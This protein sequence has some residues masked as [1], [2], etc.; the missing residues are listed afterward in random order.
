M[1]DPYRNRRMKAVA[2]REKRMGAV[3]FSLPVD[4]DVLQTRTPVAAA[5]SLMQSIMAGLLKESTPFFDEIRARWRELFP[6]LAARPGKWAA[7][8]SGGGKVFIHVSSAS[9]L[10]ALRPKLP[11]IRKKLAALPSA[12]ARFSV[13]LEI[14]MV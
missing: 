11:A 12:P 4:A 2:A 1:S 13:H 3:D 5:G 9:A 10:F 14:H 7:S 6:D 8:P